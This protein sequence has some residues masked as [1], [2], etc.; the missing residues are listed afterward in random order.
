M[1]KINHYR[2]QSLLFAYIMLIFVCIEIFLRILGF[3]TG[4]EYFLRVSPRNI[5][6]EDK[7]TGWKLN[8]GDYIFAVHDSS[9]IFKAKINKNE[10]RISTPDI[11][12]TAY[13]K[14]KPSI[15]IYG[16]SFTFGFS[17]ADSETSSY[18]LQ[19]FLPDYRVVNK[20]V[21]GYGL[22]QMYLSLQESLIKCDTPKIVIF[23]YG[24]FHDERTVLHRGC[25]SLIVKAI[26]NGSSN[27]LKN[28]KYPYIYMDNNKSK[29]SIVL[30]Y[31]AIKNLPKF[32]SFHNKSVLIGLLN[33]LYDD[34]HDKRIEDQLHLISE[35]TALEMM[36]F[37]KQN[38]II[39]IFA[40]VTPESTDILSNLN[41]RGFL[42]LNYGI[43]IDNIINGKPQPG[44]YNC[45]I[46]DPWHP[47]SIAHRIYAE[48]LYTFFNETKILK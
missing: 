42:T 11:A 48:K 17:V 38:G 26:S 15:H 23:N 24:K 20:G 27:G 36:I 22:T 34:Y 8:E 45:G 21:P 32:W 9:N 3:H 44:K 30:E 37:C 7:T 25:S 12:D 10:S 39:P 40:T 28:M 33:N 6:K 13:S 41:N 18:I 16:C 35:K 19:Q 31:C 5:F 46:T 2:K 1:A 29:D 4:F 43:N 14:D 47:N